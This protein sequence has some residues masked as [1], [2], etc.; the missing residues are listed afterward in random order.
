MISP[1][2]F[3][4]RVHRGGKKGKEGSKVHQFTLPQLERGFN[5]LGYKLIVHILVDNEALSSCAILSTALIRG[6]ETRMHD[7]NMT[8]AS[9]KRGKE[10]E[11]K[12]SAGK[13]QTL[14]LQT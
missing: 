12:K 1:V 2:P 13:L 10:E 9:E 4:M 8:A 11:E 3:R 5:K 14:F 6:S 7:L